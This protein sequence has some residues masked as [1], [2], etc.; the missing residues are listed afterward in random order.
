MKRKLTKLVSISCDGPEEEARAYEQF[1]LF[2][3]NDKTKIEN[4]MKLD[5]ALWGYC[6][7]KVTGLFRKRKK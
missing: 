3:S 1:H 4:V 7:Y 2:G 5:E 6:L